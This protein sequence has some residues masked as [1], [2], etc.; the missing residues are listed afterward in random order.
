MIAGGP[1]DN[2]GMTRPVLPGRRAA[3]MTLPLAWLPWPRP[4]RASEPAPWRSAGRP[5][6]LALRA[7]ALLHDAAEH[8]LDP[9][10]YDVQALADGAPALS[11]ER[12]ERALTSRFEQ[13]LSDLH[14]GRI[15]PRSI[16]QRFEVAHPPPYDAAAALRAARGAGD[17]DAAVQAAAPS[18]HQY[19]QL[20]QALAVYRALS[21][22]PAWTSPLPKLP[23][24]V[25]AGRGTKLEPGMAWPGLAPLAARLAA[26]GDLRAGLGAGPDV[27]SSPLVDAVRAFQERHG[28]TA[29]GVLGPATQAAL[30]VTPAERAQQIGLAM[31]RLRW[32]PLMRGRRMIAVNIPE[33]VLRGYEVRDGQIVVQ[34]QMKVIVGRA[35]DQR[36]PLFDETM[37]SIEFSPYWNVPPSIARQETVPRLRRDPAYLAR[38]GF[39]FVGADGQGDT[40]LTAAK[41]DAV[42][43]GQL[44]IRQRPG[45]LN[46]LG[47]IKFVFPNREHIYLHH[48]PSTGLFARDRRDLSHG[49]IR[50]E[51]PVALARFVLQDQP[52]WDETRIRQAMGRGQSSTLAL[53]DPLPVLIAYG[54]SLVKSGRTWFFQDIYGHDRLLDAAL[55]ARSAALASTRR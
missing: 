26:M 17:L 16:H 23:P 30:D 49:C 32:T 46:A 6:P 35:L 48:T 14:D 33:F 7:L 10:D 5:G 47:D 29:D 51:D 44:R 24:P 8:G 50:V 27:Y 43:A 12:F 9:R 20:K 41:L 39:E 40:V 52:G 19:G 13:F 15:D 21:G 4:A 54:T 53:R 28:L 1:A 31:E 34:T 55:R 3:L 25:R 37:R 11:D 2:G 45:P 42:L 22:H 38:Q 36:T 18:L